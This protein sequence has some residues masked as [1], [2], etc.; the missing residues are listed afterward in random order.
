MFVQ[1]DLLRERIGLRKESRQRAANGGKPRPRRQVTNENDDDDDDDFYDRT[2]QKQARDARRRR[3]RHGDVPVEK[4]KALSLDELKAKS[5]ELEDEK[6]QLTVLQEK[7][8]AEGLELSQGESS[9]KEA[10]DPLVAY[11]HK[12]QVEANKAEQE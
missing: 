9:A 2:G 5:Q 12:T 1:E 8:A 11:M 4:K 10:S 7:L 3:L 6:S